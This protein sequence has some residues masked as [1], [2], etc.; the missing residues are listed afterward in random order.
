[1]A[2]SRLIL[3]N[4]RTQFQNSAHYSN[5]SASTG[6]IFAADQA[7]EDLRP[8]QELM[9]RYQHMKRDVQ[10]GAFLEWGADSDA[11]AA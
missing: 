1:G 8:L 10:T 11:Q 3:A 9:L 5:L 4:N 7:G 6:S 2:S